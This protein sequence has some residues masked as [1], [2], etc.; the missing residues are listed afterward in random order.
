[1]SLPSGSKLQRAF[2]CTASA[3]LPKS[4]TIS[5]QGAR[6]TGVHGFLADLQ[7]LSRDEALARV[8][9]EHRSAC[10]AINLEQIP[11]GAEYT[12]ELAL[13]Y[14]VD[15]EKTRII[16]KDVAGNYGELGEAEVPMQL[17]LTGVGA[18]YVAV[19]DYKTGRGYVPSARRNW[20]LKVGAL[21]MARLA[22]RDSARTA[23]L[24]VPDGEVFHDYAELDAFDLMGVASDLRL[25]KARIVVEREHLAA[26]RA[27][28]PESPSHPLRTVAG[29]HCRYCPSFI[30]CPAQATIVRQVA[31]EPEKVADGIRALLSPETAA[32]AYERLKLVREV[33]KQVEKA[34]H[35]YAAQNPIALGDGMVFGEVVRE[36]EELD[37][38]VVRDVVRQLHGLE[39]ADKACEL[40]TSK[41]AIDR[42]VRG[43]YEN[44][45]RLGQK[46][47]LKA[48]SAEVLRAVAERKGVHT[49]QRAE[50]R[51]HK[52]KP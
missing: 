38:V 15:T 48:L 22:G 30:Y 44:Q 36:V 6:G 28:A 33:M 7:G 43:V 2:L 49:K 5:E 19:L 24:H 4:E 10:E 32:R 47:T 39:V 18:D 45:K 16:G 3:V 42:A 21:A 29:E 14:D 12:P 9:E 50:V 20:Q 46:V 11:I 8:S 40:E 1:M 52:V 31:G 34:L 27:G 41:A 25:L 23:I 51:E 17:D 26:I 13:A 35:A 37:P